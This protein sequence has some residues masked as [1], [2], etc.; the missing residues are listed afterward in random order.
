MFPEAPNM[1]ILPSGPVPPFPT[2]MLSSEAMRA[3][4]E[5]LGK[6]YTHIVIDFSAGPVGDRCRGYGRAW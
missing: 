1:D 6:V 5:R 4:M 2:E 3:L